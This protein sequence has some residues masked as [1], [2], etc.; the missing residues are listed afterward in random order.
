MANEKELHRLSEDIK[1]DCQD[2]PVAIGQWF[3]ARYGFEVVQGRCKAIL[4]SGL[5]LSFRWGLLWRETFFIEYSQILGRVPDPR[6]IKL[7]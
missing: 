7:W 5:M 1:V 2:K 3:A 4:P 6:F